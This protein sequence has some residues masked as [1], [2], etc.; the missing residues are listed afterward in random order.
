VGITVWLGAAFN[1][2]G[3]KGGGCDDAGVGIA[4]ANISIDTKTNTRGM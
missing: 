3:G 4:N 1:A 2:F